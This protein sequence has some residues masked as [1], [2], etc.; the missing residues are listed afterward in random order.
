MIDA[1]PTTLDATL[2][3]PGRPG[4]V[5]DTA[6]SWIAQA[7][8]LEEVAT[9]IRRVS[10]I[11]AWDGPAARAAASQ[12]AEHADHWQAAAETYREGATVLYGYADDLESAQ[13]QAIR[14]A[15]LF[16][17]ADAETRRAQS[18]YELIVDEARRTAAAAGAPFVIPREP[19][20]A[21][22]EEMHEQAMRWLTE[23]REDLQTAATRCSSALAD[24]SVTFEG[25]LRGLQFVALAVLLTQEEILR[26]TVNDTAAFGAALLENPD[27]LLELLGGLGGMAG[28]GALFLAGLGWSVI[29]GGVIVGGGEA[30]VAGGAIATAGAGLAGT[31]I[32]TLSQRGERSGIEIW[33]ARGPDRGDGRFLDG[34]WSNGRTGYYDAK[35][36]EQKVLDNLEDDL[37]LPIERRQVKAHIEGEKQDGRFF[38]GLI[39]KPDGTYSGVEVK[40]GDARYGGTQKHFDGLIS[41]ENPAIAKLDGQEIRITEVIRAGNKN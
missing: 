4:D 29:P 38:D 28:G 8:G 15:D 5:R 30:V 2:F 11:D 27:L 31:A 16:A 10:F 21:H 17:R 9:E 20:H 33:Q 14:A 23:A 19:S 12:I 36:A 41:S 39:R 40:T 1:G 7:I 32:G 13:R 37:Q 6:D 24:H 18:L 25:L 22:A 3:I 34:T 35:G 26:N